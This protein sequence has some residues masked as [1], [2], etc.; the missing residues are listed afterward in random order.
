MKK[1]LAVLLS[2]VMVASIV[3]CAGNTGTESTASG[4]AEPAKTPA[5][6]E[7][8]NSAASSSGPVTIR[9]A[10]NHG[11]Y[12]TWLKYIDD[13]SKAN[14]D[15]INLVVENEPNNDLRTKLTTDM[16]ANN[17]PDIFNYWTKSS[18]K[19]FIDNGMILNIDEYFAKSKVNK[20]DQWPADSF[21]AFNL[22]GSDTAYGWPEQGST[23]VLIANKEL[24]AKYSL[25]Y[26]T[27]YEELLNVS[28][29][30]N[31]NGII[32]LAIGSQ[33][34]DAG[35]W[36]YSSLFFQYAS[37][38]ELQEITSVPDKWK[39]SAAIKKASDLILDM[40]KNRVFPADTMAN[41]LWDPICA[42]YNE[43][44]AAMMVLFPWTCASISDE[45]A[46]R[47]VHINVPRMPNAINDPATFAVGGTNFGGCI[48]K[49]SWE[50]PAKNGAMIEVLDMLL[51]D[52]SQ[53]RM[54]EHGWQSQK[55]LEKYPDNLSKGIFKLYSEAEKGYKS[56]PHHMWSMMPDVTSRE[57]YMDLMDGLYAQTITADDFV[58]QVGDAVNEDLNK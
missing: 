34:G 45:A 15:R 7:A 12:D 32:P 53:Y 40:A 29:V 36:F 22:D 10:T 6:S 28:K 19:T 54:Y 35:F 31:K 25:S 4:G 3:A 56:I 5:S 17:M 42:L 9:Y 16:A 55:I 52:E 21:K 47:S 39:S 18:L 44:K 2:L 50:D 41:G 26:P 13:W 20:R 38:A 8:G 46:A 57:L 14:K 58:R 51:G 27:T 48:Y 43:Q 23:N 30:F 24:F 49:P 11:D 1:L 37:S 33:H